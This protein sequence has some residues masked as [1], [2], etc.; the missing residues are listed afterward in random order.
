MRR[1]NATVL[2]AEAGERIAG[3]AAYW[4]SADEGELGDLAVAPEMR[5]RGVGRSLVSAVRRESLRRGVGRIYLQV[6]ESNGPA[7]ELYAQAGFE[8]I[9]RRPSYYRQPEEDAI[10]M[11]WEDA[12]GVSG[13]R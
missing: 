9:G 8:E 10:I 6:R 13:S 2:V 7:R 4:C 12:A 5:R 3:Y 1:E 11:G